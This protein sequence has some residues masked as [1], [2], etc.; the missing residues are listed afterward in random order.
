MNTIL[1]L[2]LFALLTNLGHSSIIVQT[3]HGPV[4]GTTRTSDLGREYFS[5]M[6]IPY[7]KP[8]EGVLKFRVSSDWMFK[9]FVNFFLKSWTDL[10][11]KCLFFKFHQEPETPEPWIEPLNCTG[12]GSQFWNANG[13]Q[14][15]VVGSFDSLHVNVFTDN[16]QP[17][18]LYPVMF[19]IHGGSYSM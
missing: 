8:A 15:R 13:W 5:F 12:E 16:L 6:G 4:E 3:Q 9:I 2:A 10:A 19:Y 17:E 7:A 11:W 18:V 14:Q 1:T